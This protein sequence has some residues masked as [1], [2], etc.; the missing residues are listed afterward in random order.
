MDGGVRG[1]DLGGLVDGGGSSK[2]VLDEWMG[3]KGK[4]VIWWKGF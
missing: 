2:W 3:I 4:W 1:K